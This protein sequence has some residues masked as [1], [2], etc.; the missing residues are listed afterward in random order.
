MPISGAAKYTSDVPVR[1]PREGAHPVALPEP[2]PGERGGQPADPIGVVGVGVA[3]QP[4]PGHARRERLFVEE[5]P[6]ALEEVG[7]RER[8]VHDQALHRLISLR[9]LRMSRSESRR[10][11]A[12]RAR[13]DAR[14][15]AGASPAG[16]PGPS[17]WLAPR[18]T[19]WRR[20]RGSLAPVVGAVRVGAVLARRPLAQIAHDV[21]DARRARAR[22]PAAHR[23]RG[24]VCAARRPRAVR[25][26]AARR[27]RD[28]AARRRR[29]PPSP[30]PP[31]W[32]AACR[33][34][35]AVVARAEPGHL[36]RGMGLV[37]RIGDPAGPLAR[38]PCSPRRPRRQPVDARVGVVRVE[39]VLALRAAQPAHVEERRELAIG[40]LV[41]VDLEML[42]LEAVGGS[43]VGAVAV[44]AHGERAAV[45]EHH[46]VCPCGR[47]GAAECG[48]EGKGNRDPDAGAADGRGTGPPVHNGDVAARAA[49]SG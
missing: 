36:D 7:E 11:M 37:A 39:I 9:G 27:P 22:G 28:S 42:Q 23:L 40:D 44:A 29:A 47:R 32:A 4:H 19:G 3:L 16:S 10:V 38:P 25:R 31:R 30:T 43:L 26:R 14:S 15:V 6:R 34:P 12:A 2:E 49:T 46:A 45:D 48:D 20:G 33:L 17:S 24:V 21:L 41:A 8:I 5:L 18:T 35:E 1:V 13:R